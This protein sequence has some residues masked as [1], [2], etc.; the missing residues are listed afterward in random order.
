MVNAEDIIILKSNINR[1]KHALFPLKS[2]ETDTVAYRYYTECKPK[3]LRNAVGNIN[4]IEFHCGPTL[5]YGI[6]DP[7]CHKILK[8]IATAYDKE[9]GEFM[10]NVLIFE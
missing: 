4:G 6:E 2:L 8:E 5:M 7:Q 10:Y 9:S 1:F 3:I